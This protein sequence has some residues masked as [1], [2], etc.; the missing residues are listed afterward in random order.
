MERAEDSGPWPCERPGAQLV[1]LRLPTQPPVVG[2]VVREGTGHYIAR[3]RLATGETQNPTEEIA[4]IVSAALGY[5]VALSVRLDIS[6]PNVPA[7]IVH[8]LN[9]ALA[10]AVAT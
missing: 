1:K 3:A 8:R 9:E 2:P 6:D 4:N 10:K 7:H 5:G